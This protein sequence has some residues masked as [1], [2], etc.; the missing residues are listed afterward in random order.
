MMTHVEE[1]LPKLQDKFEKRK[2]SVVTMYSFYRFCQTLRNDEVFGQCSASFSFFKEHTAP[3]LVSKLLSDAHPDKI[4]GYAF[5]DDADRPVSTRKRARVLPKPTMS[6]TSTTTETLVPPPPP[7]SVVV[8]ASLLTAKI[9]D[10]SEYR[11]KVTNAIHKLERR[12]W[13]SSR[14]LEKL[15]D[16]KH[17]LSKCIHRLDDDRRSSNE[18]SDMSTSVYNLKIATYAFEI[19]ELLQTCL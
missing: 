3:L 15:K 18:F 8:N 7:P 9:P 14:H 1:L 13:S 11:A 17:I 4:N 16:F 6:S 10:V 5:S 12:P 19:D 2:G